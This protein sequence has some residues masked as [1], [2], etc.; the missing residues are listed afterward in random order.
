[1]K[2]L[3][4][5]YTIE[6]SYVLAITMFALASIIITAYKERSRIV[7]GFVTHTANEQLAYTDKKYAVDEY[8]KEKIEEEAVRYKNN[9]SNLSSSVFDISL[10]NNKARTILKNSVERVEV[11][12]ESYNPE[13]FMR[14]STLMEN[15]YE[16]FRNSVQ[17]KP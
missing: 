15:I 17:E 3:K 6:A 7:M 13:D 10:N 14:M 9:I 11:A 12:Q 5:S 8:N 4:A 2:R 16:S 1:M